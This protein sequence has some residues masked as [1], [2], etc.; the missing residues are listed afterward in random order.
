MA[1]PPNCCTPQKRDACLFFSVDSNLGG[2]NT[3]YKVNN[4]NSKTNVG[5]FDDQ[6]ELRSDSDLV[7]AELSELDIAFQMRKNSQNL[8]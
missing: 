8:I 7:L 5:V 3:D 1:E 4:Q 2:H 6:V